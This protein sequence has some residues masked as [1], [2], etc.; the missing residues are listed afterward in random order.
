MVHI[1]CYDKHLI[2]TDLPFNKVCWN[3]SGVHEAK[4]GVL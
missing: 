1:E 2:K 3:L 4:E